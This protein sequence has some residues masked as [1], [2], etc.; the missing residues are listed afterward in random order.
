[1]LQSELM[2]KYCKFG[3]GIKQHSQHQHTICSDIQILDHT[4]SDEN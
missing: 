3:E 1:M 2:G 4:N